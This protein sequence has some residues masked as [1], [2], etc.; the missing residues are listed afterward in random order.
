MQSFVVMA[1]VDFVRICCLYLRGV[2]YNITLPKKLCYLQ[3]D[4]RVRV[5]R[6]ELDGLIFKAF[7]SHQ[8]YLLKDLIRRT[9]QPQAFVKEA[10]KDVCVCV[11]LGDMAVSLL[12]ADMGDQNWW[13]SFRVFLL[14]LGSCKRTLHV[15]SKGFNHI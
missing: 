7:Q 3:K 9:D 14:V 15:N 11:Y 10:L 13:Y 4:K 5:E 6:E 1:C 2:T 8:Y 12:S